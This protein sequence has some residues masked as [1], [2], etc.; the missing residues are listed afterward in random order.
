MLHRGLHALFHVVVMKI[1]GR[2]C[3]SISLGLVLH[4]TSHNQLQLTMQLYAT[5]CTWLQLWL[6]GF[7]ESLGPVSVQLCPKKA[8]KLDQTRLWNTNASCVGKQTVN[9]DKGE[10]I[11]LDNS[12]TGRVSDVVKVPPTYPPNHNQPGADPQWTV[13]HK[14]C[15][16]LTSF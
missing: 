12:Q 10:T 11:R 8:K 4:A 16:V 5:G 1:I 15:K 7:V 2:N 6:H 14:N 9:N 13:M 3:L